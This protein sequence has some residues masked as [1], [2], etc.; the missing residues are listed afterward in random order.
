MPDIGMRQILGVAYMY[1]SQEIERCYSKV[2]VNNVFVYVCLLL[3]LLAEVQLCLPAFI[4]F[5]TC[6]SL[7]LHLTDHG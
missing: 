5:D 1:L 7:C 4:T 6:I 2:G 3:S